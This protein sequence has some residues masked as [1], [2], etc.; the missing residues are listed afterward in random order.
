M[1]KEQT[2][3]QIQR[4]NRIKLLS[5]LALMLAPVII[6]YGIFFSDYRPDSANYGEILEIKKISG[7]GINQVDNTIFRMKDLHGKWVLV[8]VDSGVC[9]EVCQTQ[10]FHLRQVRLVQNKEMSRVER[11]WLIDDNV[12]VDAELIEKYEG[13]HFINA[14][15]SE[16]LEFIT[17]IESQRN[18]VYVVDPMGNL[19]MRFPENHDP[20]LVGK[21]IKHLLDVSQ[22]EH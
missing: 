16:L 21:D 18:H 9:D 7:S 8:M 2:K 1:S 10:I 3:E 17:P 14:R 15:D 22:M 5:L 12:K 6:S 13:T 19:M 20:T 4:N 11:L